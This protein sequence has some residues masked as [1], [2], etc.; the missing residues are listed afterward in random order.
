MGVFG[1][2]FLK[3]VCKQVHNQNYLWETYYGKRVL[4]WQKYNLIYTATSDIPEEE[5]TELITS[6]LITLE[7]SASVNRGFS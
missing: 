5:L 1:T 4:I 6:Q 2:K 3:A 7:N